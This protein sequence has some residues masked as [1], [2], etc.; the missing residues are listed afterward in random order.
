M[1]ICL[2][3]IFNAKHIFCYWILCI[4]H[5]RVQSEATTW[6]L[7]RPS[8]R[9]SVLVNI[10]VF[11]SWHG[12]IVMTMTMLLLTPHLARQTEQVEL[13][14]LTDVADL[15]SQCSIPGHHMWTWHEYDIKLCDTNPS[16]RSLNC[17]KLASEARNSSL[18]FSDWPGGYNN[19]T[20]QK[21]LQ[22]IYKISRSA[23]W[24]HTLVTCEDVSVVVIHLDIRLG[25]HSVRA[26]DRDRLT[27]YIMGN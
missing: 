27:N 26:E 7:M 15:V 12:T 11:S 3:G 24:W 20:L 17:S 22:N 4:M 19:L 14:R 8:L 1:D 18:S 25:T 6:N 13:N 23:S 9:F 10:S 16:I 2:T 21:Y 5:D